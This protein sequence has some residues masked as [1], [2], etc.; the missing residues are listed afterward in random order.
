M[1]CC[2]K[3]QGIIIKTYR[4]GQTCYQFLYQLKKGNAN[5]VWK[6]ISTYVATEMNCSSS[7]ISIKLHGE[8]LMG[9]IM[10][11]YFQLR[12]INNTYL[13]RV[14]AGL[15]LNIEEIVMFLPYVIKGIE[16]KL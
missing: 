7:L 10:G 4:K 8:W 14:L 15:Y 16:R 5:R 13:R 6:R 2:K 3:I 1:S 11:I 9:K 12:E